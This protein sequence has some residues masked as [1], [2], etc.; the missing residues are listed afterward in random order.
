MNSQRQIK[1]YP[2]R[3]LYDPA[4]RRYITLADIYRFVVSGIDFV[5]VENIG[6]KDITDHILLQVISEQEQTGKLIFGREFLLKAIRTHGS[7]SRAPFGE[8]LRLQRANG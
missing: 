6:Q 1:K 3:R 8:H 7:P 2:N 4:E 5:V